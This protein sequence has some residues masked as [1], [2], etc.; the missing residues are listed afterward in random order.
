MPADVIHLAAHRA[1]LSTRMP[2]VGL[3]AGPPKLVGSRIM[4]P[5]TN[6]DEALE[7]VASEALYLA[8]WLLV[9]AESAQAKAELEASP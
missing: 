8:A 6:D 1:R 2:G 9:L 3:L 7:L 5:S 4:V